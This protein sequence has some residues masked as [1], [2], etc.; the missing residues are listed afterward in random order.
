MGDLVAERHH[1]GL[2]QIDVAERLGMTRERLAF[3][4]TAGKEVE[5]TE[6]WAALYMAALKEGQG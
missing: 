2:R 5:P 4:E 3:L 1:Y 6:E